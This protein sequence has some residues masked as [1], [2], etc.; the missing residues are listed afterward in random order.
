MVVCLYNGEVQLWNNQVNVCEY[1]FVAG[2]DPVRA[3][4]IHSTQSIIITGCDD[5]TINAWDFALKSLEFTFVGHRDFI[6]SVQFHS[7]YP[8]ILSASDDR[9]MRIWDMD[10]K[11]CIH[12]ITG[13]TF[14]VMSAFFHHSEDW[15]VSASMDKTIRVWDF[16]ELVN[17]Q[18]LGA[19]TEPSN[20]NNPD[21]EMNV[22]SAS[23][24][25]LL[26]KSSKPSIGPVGPI[27][28]FDFT[29][30][31]KRNDT[32][33]GGEKLGF[34][35]QKYVLKGHSSG[36]NYAIFHP[37]QPLIVSCGDDALVKVWDMTAVSE[38]E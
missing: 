4:A 6:R 17:H 19:A 22:N 11:E 35:R 3:V 18:T 36:V 14:C 28:H 8:W 15:I 23:Y 20:E 33:G 37:T 25:P 16:A 34:I 27:K 32:T 9:T 30:M 31:G 12:I 2:R 29:S 26:K 38:W 24:V 13:H 7:K 5:S 10:L 1:S 21:L